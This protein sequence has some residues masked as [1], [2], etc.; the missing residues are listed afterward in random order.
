MTSENPSNNF[1]EYGYRFVVS[2]V[3]A[4]GSCTSGLMWISFAPLANTL[5]KAYGIS[6]YELNSL[7]LLY[8]GLYLPSSL[9]AQ[10]FI[11]NLDLRSSVL[12][13]S[14]L[15]AL[16]AFLRLFI[17]K[18]GFGIVIAGQVFAAIGQPFFLNAVTKL[19]VDWYRPKARSIATS[20][21]FAGNQIGVVLGFF[22]PSLFVQWNDTTPIEDIR[23]QV[24]QFVTFQ[25]GVGVALLLLVLSFFK[26]KPPTPPGVAAIRATENFKEALRSS[27]LSKDYMAFAVG[28]ALNLSGYIAF[29]TVLDSLIT[30]L[31]YGDSASQS[32]GTAMNI[33]SVIG[34]LVAG[35]IV[36][37]PKALRTIILVC[38]G[39]NA[40]FQGALVEILRMNVEISFS[41]T[42]VILG[43]LY[44]ASWP[45][46]AEFAC[47]V[48]YPRGEGSTLGIMNSLANIFSIINILIL[49]RILEPKTVEAAISA[50]LY[51]TVCLFAGTVLACLSR[52]KVHRHEAEVS[53]VNER[54][55]PLTQTQGDERTNGNP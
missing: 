51:I 15:T 3:F 4:I 30:P 21:L 47:E 55:E 14:S 41:I 31:G 37:S 48:N 52:N 7:G 6:S 25:A 5:E 28:Y 19:T 45:L 20:V 12:T 34:Q 27:L 39:L 26:S 44:C 29:S 1:R 2:A 46:S 43:L 53:L 22:I 9:L 16:G 13:A 32:A 54:I 36:T 23:G 42:F 33:T 11:D 24:G 50:N 17:N 18:T 8:S 35:L 40:L 49:T 38:F 10:Y